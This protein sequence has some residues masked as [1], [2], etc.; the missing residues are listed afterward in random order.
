MS[1][2]GPP[3]AAAAGWYHDGTTW[4]WWDG[5]AWQGAPGGP[6][7]IDAGK[8]LAVLSHIPMTGFVLPLVVYLIEKDKNRYSRHHAAEALNLAILMVIAQLL[9]FGVAFVIMI[10]GIASSASSTTT[11]KDADFPPAFFVGFMGI[12]G[13]T[14]LMMV[15]Q[16]GLGIWGAI[17]ASQG[18]WF[19]Y[20]LPFRLVD[21]GARTPD[22]S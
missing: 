7:E 4:R 11:T 18:V 14:M 21:R 8:T 17:R 5:Q 6:G 19:R 12:W 1:P 9:T 20:P 3:T 16:W 15:A 22:E 2:L 13:A 10:A